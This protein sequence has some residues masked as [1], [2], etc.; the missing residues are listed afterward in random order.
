MIDLKERRQT[1]AAAVD[2]AWLGAA[3]APDGKRLYVSGGADD[4][5]LRFDFDAGALA[6]P[7]TVTLFKE[8]KKTTDAK[9]RYSSGLAITPDGGTAYVAAQLAACLVKADLRSSPTRH[10]ILA[11]FDTPS[12]NPYAVALHPNGR[13]AYVSLWGGSAVAEVRLRDGQMRVLSTDPHPNHMVL[14][15]DGSRLFVACANTNLVDV[16]DTR[17]LRVTE[18]LDTAMFPNMPAGST[19]NGLALSA[20]GKTLLVANADNN[21]L[22]V[23]DVSRPG[24]SVSRGFIPTGWYPTAAGFAPDG[25]I[26]VVNGKGEGTLANPEG[27]NPASRKA[28]KQYIGG[29]LRGSVS[30]IEKPDDEQMRRHSAEA[31]KTTPLRAD[32]APVI[33]PEPGNPVPAKV[34][35]PSPITHCVYIIKENRTYDQVLGDMPEGNGDPTLCLFGEKVTPNHHALAREFVLLDNFYVESEVSAD[36]HEWTMGAYATDFVEKT[37]PPLYG[38]HGKLGYPAEGSNPARP[39]GRATSGTARRRRAS[40]TAATASS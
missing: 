33:A 29:L 2:N 39:R 11:R 21:T 9:P 32:L 25:A 27:P 38:G 5:A 10:E 24:A 30:F 14:S 19:P 40:P 12:A 6:A 8:E 18:R 1:A 20:D 34:G 35:D 26:F 7:T 4:C 16:I 15:K 3:F 22:A 23:F 17:K 31:L 37:W 13:V 28:A 36:G